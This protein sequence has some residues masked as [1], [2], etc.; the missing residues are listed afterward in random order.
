MRVITYILTTCILYIDNIQEKMTEFIEWPYCYSK[1]FRRH[2]VLGT[3]WHVRTSAGEAWI[4][5]DGSASWAKCYSCTGD[6]FFILNS[7]IGRTITVYISELLRTRGSDCDD[8]DIATSSDREEWGLG[9]RMWHF[10]TL[11]QRIRHF[12]AIL[13]FIG[14]SHTSSGAQQS[15]PPNGG[16]ISSV[17]SASAG[18]IKIVDLTYF[19]SML[20]TWYTY[21]LIF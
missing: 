14:V 20:W 17:S 5:G 6:V 7:L 2:G 11:E 16:G 8:G 19:Q 10:E 13:T 9:Q 3:E 15:P 4:H 18:M 12:K 1:H 21:R